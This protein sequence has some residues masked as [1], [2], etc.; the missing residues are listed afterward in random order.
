MHVALSRAIWLMSFAVF[1]SLA[2]FA[3]KKTVVRLHTYAAYA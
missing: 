1:A 3:L 2:C